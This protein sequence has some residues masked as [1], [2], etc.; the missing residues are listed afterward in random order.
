M[1]STRLQRHITTI[2]NRVYF[3]YTKVCILFIVVVLFLQLCNKY[4]LKYTNILVPCTCY[5]VDN[6]YY[7]MYRLDN[8]M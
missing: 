1:S 4:I 2:N 5:N 6:M 8:N 7:S 3:P